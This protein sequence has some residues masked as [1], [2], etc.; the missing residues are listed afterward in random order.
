MRIISSF[1][2]DTITNFQGHRTANFVGKFLTLVEQTKSCHLKRQ[3][4]C[5][6]QPVSDC[7]CSFRAMTSLPTDNSQIPKGAEWFLRLQAYL[8]EQHIWLYPTASGAVLKFQLLGMLWGWQNPISHHP[9]RLKGTRFPVAAAWGSSLRTAMGSWDVWM[10]LLK[11]EFTT[12]RCT[13]QKQLVLQLCC[14]PQKGKI[15]MVMP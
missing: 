11:K 8:S 13:S 6:P 1:W 9:D 7:G 2:V 15:P 12:T 5:R 4:Y 3:Q 10:E 14:N